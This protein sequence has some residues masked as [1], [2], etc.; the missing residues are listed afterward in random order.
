MTK[1]E[2][3]EKLKGQ[4]IVSCQA[5]ED[6]PLYYDKMSLMP[7]MAKAALKA[8]AKGI[9]ANSIRDIVA[10][11]KEVNLPIIGIIKKVYEGGPQHI[12][13][14][15]KEVDELVEAKTDVIALDC[16]L[17]LRYDGSTINEYVSKIK[18]KYPNIILMAD[19]ST[20]E[21]AVNAEKMGIDFIGTTL[22]GYTPYSKKIDGPD[23]ELVKKIV[24]NLNTPVIAEGKIHTPEQAKKMLDLG[25]H[26]VVVG[27][28]IT[29][30]YEIAT[31]FVKG[32]GL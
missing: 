20:Y 13:V 16:T 4:L 30:P 17:R 2:I 6:E 24:E 9:R 11:K 26:C 29:R 10:I 8:G 1:E 5:L 19:I 31:R 27:G 21:E 18:E 3:L 23:F 15:M 28:A 12:T 7:F 25:V 32:M 14:S 22:S